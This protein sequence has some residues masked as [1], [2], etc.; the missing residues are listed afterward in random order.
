MGLSLQEYLFVPSN[1]PLITLLRYCSAFW[2]VLLLTGCAV[3]PL[4]AVD[5]P[6]QTTPL[7]AVPMQHHPVIALALGGGASRGFA[8]VGVL[9][10]LQRNGIKPD[11]V[12]SASDV[13]Q[14]KVA[15]RAP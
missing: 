14:R 8:H 7:K 2:L 13:A 6:P 15:T 12:D 11:I 10:V 5:N 4:V 1:I 9:N 3:T